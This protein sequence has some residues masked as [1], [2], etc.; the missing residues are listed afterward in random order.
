MEPPRSPY[1]EMKLHGNILIEA[2]PKN[3]SSAN[4]QV[5]SAKSNKGRECDLDPSYEAT[6]SYKSAER[7]MFHEAVINNGNWI[8][9]LISFVPLRTGQMI[10]FLLNHILL[11]SEELLSI[12]QL[13]MKNPALLDE[14][15]SHVSLVLGIQSAMQAR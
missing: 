5:A 3:E 14:R 12:E 10:H 7:K 13:V 6:K 11:A 2:W 8:K 1:Q 9:E 4:H 15:R